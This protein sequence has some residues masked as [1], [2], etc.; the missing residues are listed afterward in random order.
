MTNIKEIET[1]DYLGA[2][3]PL[4]SIC[5]PT[6]DQPEALARLL[7]SFVK[8]R[9]DFLIEILVNDGSENG[10][11]AEIVNEYSQYVNMRY[12]K[13]IGNDIDS[14]IIELVRDARGDYIWFI[15]DDELVGGA[16]DHIAS[17]QGIRE[18]AE[19]IFVETRNHETGAAQINLPLSRYFKDRDEL[20]LLAGTGLAFISSNIFRSDIAEKNLAYLEQFRGTDFCNFALSISVI[21]NSERHFYLNQPL[22]INYPHSIQE[23]KR[24]RK[25]TNGLPENNFFNIFGVSWKKILFGQKKHFRASTL[26]T[27]VRSV[28]SSTW[29]GVVV[30]WAGGWDTPRGKKFLLLKHFWNLP[31]A[32]FVFVIFLLPT[33]FIRHSYRFYKIIR[34]L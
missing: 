24:R 30:G 17:C 3:N 32:W 21:A 15:G 7:K 1:L 6:R 22:V 34:L 20:L 18:R 26:R 9:R 2:S 28:F 5:I 12:R 4:L 33:S 11:A 31:E 25:F 29:K 16:I 23:H 8:E 19:F 10:S 14:G 13:R 27:S